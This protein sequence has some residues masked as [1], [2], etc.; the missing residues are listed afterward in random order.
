[1]Q[2]PPV[3]RTERTEEGYPYPIPKLNLQRRHRGTPYQTLRLRLPDLTG[4]EFAHGTEN[5]GEDTQAFTHTVLFK[6]K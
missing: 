6:N 4:V 2:G 1:M 5:L 3:R